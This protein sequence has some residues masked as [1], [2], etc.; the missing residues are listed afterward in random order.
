VVFYSVLIAKKL[1]WD[2]KSTIFKLSMAALLHD[3]GLKGIDPKTYEGGRMS[4]T[5][6]DVKLFE[7]HPYRGAS[8][9]TG[10]RSIPTEVIQAVLQ[11]HE[12]CVGTGYPYGL[13]KSQITPFSR[14]I[15]VSEAFCDMAFGQLKLSPRESLDRIV[16]VYSNA[17]DGVFVNE[18]ASLFNLPKPFKS[19]ADGSD[20]KVV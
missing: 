17:L 8:M 10:I 16:I 9:L 12:N 2:A 14:L 7:Q 6:D 15:A 1:G 5:S 13:R 4:M 18:L 20:Y 11:H 3:I 19:I